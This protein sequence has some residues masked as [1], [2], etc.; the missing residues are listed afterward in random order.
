MIIALD[1]AIDLHTTEAQY[2]ELMA[3]RMKL[4][5]IRSDEVAVSMSK[6][7]LP[8][9]VKLFWE[10]FV[11]EIEEFKTAWEKT[12][13]EIIPA[14]NDAIQRFAN[15][16][17]KY[18]QLRLSQARAESDG[19]IS[20]LDRQEEAEIAYA[21]RI[22]LGTE[23]IRAKYRKLR[24]K[25]EDEAQKKADKIRKAQKPIMIAQSIA[26]TALAV[27]RALQTKPTWLGIALAST[28]GIIG[29][30]QTA[31]IASQKFFKGGLV[32]T[33]NA[34][35]A[36]FGGLIPGTGN[37]DTVSALL[38]PG[39]FVINPKATAQFYPLL[40][41]INEFKTVSVPSITPSLAGGGVV[42][43]NIFD[44]RLFEEFKEMKEAFLDIGFEE[45][46]DGDYGHFVTKGTK[47]NRKS[48]FQ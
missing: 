34:I 48:V 37:N 6:I 31:I 3:K 39:E 11:K 38:T 25:A 23:K 12:V 28:V 8:L 43:N 44:N 47:F 15:M 46:K 41:A 17:S 22:G 24:D 4:L 33:G 36:A 26:D 5:K 30:A 16:W 20:E 21:E 18:T 42:T 29:A 1:K 40:K 14:I 7:E 2:L 10:K 13:E 9:R 45:M 19:V 32:K 35:K 27:V